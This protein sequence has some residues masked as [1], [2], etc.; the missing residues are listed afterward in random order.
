VTY[1]QGQY[2][3]IGILFTEG[4]CYVIIAAAAMNLVFKAENLKLILV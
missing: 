1:R 2:E 3:V 4:Y